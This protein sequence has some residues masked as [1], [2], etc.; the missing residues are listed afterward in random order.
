MNNVNFLLINTNVQMGDY[1]GAVLNSTIHKL[2]CLCDYF[3]DRLMLHRRVTSMC[4][5][6]LEPNC[7]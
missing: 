1:D 7:I 2:K 6:G 3:F 4:T 5:I